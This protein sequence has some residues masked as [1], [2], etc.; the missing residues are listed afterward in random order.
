MTTWTEYKAE[1]ENISKTAEAEFSMAMQ[2]RNNYP[3]NSDGYI[4]RRW[5]D[6]SIAITRAIDQKAENAR[7]QAL[8]RLLA[9]P[10]DQ[11]G[12]R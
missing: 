10:A 11:R 1:L 5:E 12:P 9:T 7:K 3:K 6:K 2:V 4:E 8:D